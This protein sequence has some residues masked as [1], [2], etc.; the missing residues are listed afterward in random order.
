[1]RGAVTG[2]EESI[3]T[4]KKGTNAAQV[5]RGVKRPVGKVKKKT[6]MA[7][8]INPYVMIWARAWKNGGVCA[9]RLNPR[10]PVAPNS[11]SSSETSRPIHSWDLRQ[12]I[13]RPSNQYKTDTATQRTAKKPSATATEKCSWSST[14]T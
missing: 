6:N 9:G 13:R 4:T 14:W 5:Q 12:K 1:M 10:K 2:S 7:G 11:T 3:V 8:H